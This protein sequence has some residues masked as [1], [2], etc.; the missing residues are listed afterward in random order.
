MRKRGTGICVEVAQAAA[1]QNPVCRD[2]W[3]EVGDRSSCGKGKVF[4]AKRR[5]GEAV[6]YGPP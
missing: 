4:P 5:N 1:R 3:N 2:K 6:S